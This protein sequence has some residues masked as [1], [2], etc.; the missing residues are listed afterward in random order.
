MEY[1]IFR[2]SQVKI[3]LYYQEMERKEALIKQRKI[4]FE[5]QNKLANHPVKD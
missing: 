2:Q 1:K 4:F 3:L 5:K